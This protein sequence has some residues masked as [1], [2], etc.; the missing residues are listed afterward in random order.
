MTFTEPGRSAGATCL[1]CNSS[2]IQAFALTGVNSVANSSFL[3]GRMRNFYI[4]NPSGTTTLNVT[5]STFDDTRGQ[6]T[7]ATDNLQIYTSGNA[8]AAFNIGA[9][10]F[11]KSA[12]NQINAVSK[13]N[14]QITELDITGIT[15]NND[16]GPSSGVRID[17]E[18]ASSLAFNLIG[19]PVLHTQD[20]NV[21][22]VSVA[23]TAQM[24]GRIA[25]NPNMRFTTASAGGSGFGGIRALSDGS[26]SRIILDVINNTLLVDNGT[27]GYGPTAQ[28]DG[29]ARIDTRVANNR[30]TAAGAPGIPLDAINGFI[31]PTV[32]PATAKVLCMTLT[33]NTVDGIWARAA[34]ARAFSPTGTYVTGYSGTFAA[35]WAA[36]GNISALPVAEFAS[37][38]GVVS[39]P[40]APCATP[41]HPMP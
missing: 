2:G 1:E 7:P 15:M 29:A 33:G 5:G 19:N 26:T 8:S 27:S 34:R 14:S 30:L 12:T 31:N 10:T 11:L 41:S 13:D 25:D 18:G 20:E 40:P 4:S 22:T 21:V 35:T 36:Q 17:A 23:G 9:S 16:G 38:G 37:G 24:Q 39:A 28:G 6:G 32:G 3:R